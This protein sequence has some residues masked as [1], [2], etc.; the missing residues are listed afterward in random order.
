LNPRILESS[1]PPGETMYQ[2]FYGLREKP[3]AL[4]P[5]PQFLFL[6]ESHRT[7]IDSLLY[8]I[9][10]REGFIV[11]T[12][13]I[14]TG[15][16]TIC[17]AVLDK[18][19]KNVN[20][21]VIFNSFLTEGKLL[22]SILQDFGF[23]SKRRTKFDRINALNE[24]LLQ[25]ISHGENA[26]LI[27][28]EAQNLSIPVLEQIRMLSNLETEKEKM[29]QII[30]F[31]QLE[32]DH[33]LRSDELKQLNQRITIRHHLLPLNRTETESYIYQ[34]LAVAGSQGGITF[35]KSALNEIYKFSKG[36]PRLINLLCDR[37]LLGGFVD[38]TFHIGKGVVKKAKEELWGEESHAVSVR[39][40]FLSKHFPPLRIALLV[41]LCILFA[42][43]ILFN[44]G[45]F[46]SFQTA[47]W[48][49]AQGIYL[50][51][52]GITPAPASTVPL[53]KKKPRPLEQKAHQEEMSKVSEGVS[54][55]VTQ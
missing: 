24:F 35:S 55:E 27:I 12:G 26:V 53:D 32:L 30:L 6:S 33:K 3:F 15:K 39:S 21:A 29:L 20:A 34:R 8:G 4:T 37:A 47:I 28:D 49:N 14:G 45:Y 43:M 9:Y 11:I 54:K 31:G 50:Q 10:Q 36:T 40:S 19:D 44:Q 25:L 13:D 48:K 1:N 5:D 2:E 41:I 42:G 7:A 38:Q 17:R 22:E 51:I 18:L 16:T 23:P 46:P 52:S